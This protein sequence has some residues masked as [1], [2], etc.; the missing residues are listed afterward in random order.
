MAGKLQG[1]IHS[2]EEKESHALPESSNIDRNDY[3]E[4]SGLAV[5][6]IAEALSENAELLYQVQNDLNEARM[7]LPNIE[8]IT[9]EDM[10]PKN[11]MWHDGKPVVIDLEC[12]DYG[13]PVSNALQLSLQWAGVTMCDVDTEKIRSFFEGYLSEYDNGFRDYDR[14]FGHSY[15]WIEWLEYNIIRSLETCR[16]KKEKRMAVDEVKN[17]LKRIRYIHDMEAELKQALRF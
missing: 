16:D 4:R 14:V 6:E 10:D 8:C 15:T 2:I 9:D 5:S 1:R 7:L 17:T 12:L 13:N 11:V 3:I